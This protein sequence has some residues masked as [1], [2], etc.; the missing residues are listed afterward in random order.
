MANCIPPVEHALKGV[1]QQMARGTTSTV[2]AWHPRRRTRGVRAHGTGGRLAAAAVVLAFLASVGATFA[3]SPPGCDSNNLQINISVF[4]PVL[5]NGDKAVYQVMVSNG[6]VA[7]GACDVSHATVTFCCPGPD[8]NPLP[9]PA[10]CIDVPIAVAPCD[11]NGDSNCITAA[12]ADNLSFPADGSQDIRVPGLQC[13]IVFNPGVTRARCKAQVNA[14]YILAQTPDGVPQPELPKLLDVFMITPTP[15]RTSTPT[16]SRTPTWTPTPTPTHT[17]TPT[18]TPTP[19][20]THT[21]S[22]TP[23]R[24]PSHT[25]TPTPTHT[26][27]PTPSPPPTPTSTPPPTATPTITPTPSPV[28]GPGDCCECTG[29]TN[30]CAPPGLSGCFLVCP[31][32][33]PAVPVY[34]AIC[35]SEGPDAGRCLT[36]TPT[37]TPGPND[38]CECPGLL[39]C[40][41][42]VSGQCGLEC[43]G[44]T[45]PAI[46]PGSVCMNAQTP[47]SGVC[48]TPTPSPTG[49][50]TPNCLDP[51]SGTFPPLIPGYCG[52]YINDCQSEICIFPPSASRPN[53]LPDNHRQCK[54][55]D[56]TCDAVLGDQQ[57]T[58]TFQICFNLDNEDRFLC[59]H[60]GPIRMVWLK[61]PRESR[62]RGSEGAPNR[63]A[64]EAAMMALGGE[65]SGFKTRS[66]AFNPPLADTVCSPP[67][68]WIVPLRQK[69]LTLLPSTYKRINW[70]SYGEGRRDGD[71]L[72]L[73]CLP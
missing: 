36:P 18:H 10:G 68:Q 54:V 73:K 45:P 59:K 31:N 29:P 63:D 42:P 28:P 16:P 52:R 14:G 61:F 55:D 64:F 69:R 21:P 2:A 30:L 41:Q 7:E 38:C 1:A 62:T 9:G 48:V 20:R 56:P 51:G 19:T 60:K 47:G 12:G 34:N 22:P 5:N 66:I 49:T 23:T 46:V 70:L 39:T 24:T 6:T 37:P 43:P 71:H 67:I 11:V 50:P 3:Q 26:H 57:C 35:I 53:G 27:T 44:G 13:T 33:T 8:G 65:I 32:G 40:S 58:F 15:T 25:S 17:H 72:F 4:P